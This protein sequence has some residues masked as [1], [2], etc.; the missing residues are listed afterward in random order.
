MITSTKMLGI[1]IDHTT[2]TAAPRRKRRQ[3]NLVPLVW[4]CCGLVLLYFVG[5]AM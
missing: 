5:R 2:R 1:L 4:L 3:S